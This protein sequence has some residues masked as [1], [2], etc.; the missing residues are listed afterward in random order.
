MNIRIIT[1]TGIRHSG[2]VHRVQF[3]S[4]TGLM[5][6]LDN[7]AP[8][9]AEVCAGKVLTDAGEYECG[10]GVLRVEDNEVTVVCG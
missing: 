8:M 10:S 9:I 1:P 5:E 6:V 3:R 2:E 4:S 7:H